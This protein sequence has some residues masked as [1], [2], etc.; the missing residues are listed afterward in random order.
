MRAGVKTNPTALAEEFLEDKHEA[1]SLLQAQVYGMHVWAQTRQAGQQLTLEQMMMDE[2]DLVTAESVGLCSPGQALIR[3]FFLAVHEARAPY[4]LSWRQQNVP[5][6]VGS[7][8]ATFKRGKALDML[9]IRQTVFSND[10]LAPA[11]S[12]WVNSASMD[13]AA[14][15]AAC[16]DYQ[17]VLSVTKMLPLK[18]L[19]LDCPSRDA[20]GAGRRFPRLVAGTTAREYHVDAAKASLVTTLANA[21][22]VISRFREAK[23]VGF[24][25]EWKPPGKV[26]TVQLSDGGEEAALFHL[27]SL[28]SVPPSLVELIKSKRLCGVKVNDDLKK[29]SADYPE[30]GLKHHL[31]DDSSIIPTANIV[32][33]SSL[34]VDVLRCAPRSCASL[35][36]LFELCHPDLELNKEICGAVWKVDWE[37]WPLEQPQLQYALNDAGASALCGL[38][39]LHPPRSAPVA[40]PP[41]PPQPAPS[42]PPVPDANHVDAGANLFNSLPTDVRANLVGGEGSGSTANAPVRTE[43]EEDDE[44]DEAHGARAAVTGDETPIDYGTM[45]TVLEAAR[46]VIDHWRESSETEPLKLPAFLTDEDRGALHPYCEGLGL[47]HETIVGTGGGEDERRLRVS[48]CTRAGMEVGGSSSD[49]VFG[50]DIMA[51]LR[52]RDDAWKLL[53]IKYDARHFMGN[54]FLMAQSKS[55]SLFKY[56]CVATSD[57][58][59]RVREGQRERVKAHLRKLFKQGEGVDMTNGSAAAAEIARVDAL[60]L[61]VKRK[62]WRSHCEYTIPEPKEVVRSLLSVYLFFKDLDDPETGRPF[63]SA[64]HEKRCVLELQYVA[65]GWLSDHPTIPLYR[66]GRV[67]KTGF[68][69][70]RCLRSSSALEGYH[71]PF[72]DAM[73]AAGH[74][75]GI[76]WMEASSNEFDWRWTVRALRTAG[77]IPQTVRHFNLAL[78]DETFDLAEQL[79]EGGGKLALPGWRR[80]KLMKAPLLCQGFHYGLEALKLPDAAVTSSSAHASEARWLADRL[81]ASEPIHTRRTA[82][83]VD[84]LMGEGADASAESLTQVALNRGLYLSPADATAFTDEV[85]ADERAR[86]LLA[87]RGY[88]ELQQA[89]RQRAP[90]RPAAPQL[91]LGATAG[92]NELPGPIGAMP[93]AARDPEQLSERDSSP[94]PDT[95]SDEEAAQPEEEATCP[96]CG[97]KGFGNAG[98]LATHVGKCSGVTQKEKRAAKKRAKR[99]DAKR[100]RGADALAGM[101]RGEV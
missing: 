52:F 25:C 3:H 62:Y 75:A 98:A 88:K 64:G 1:L 2:A 41:P 40:A 83:D 17:K 34:A 6:T 96:K 77:L 50:G 49:R 79:F 22:R 63:F 39:L 36:A 28:G 30:A 44:D 71:A 58:I 19:Y 35:K 61:R 32:E 55:S 9:K 12:V 56:F 48:R 87:E 51:R 46:D 21:Q 42:P 84:A 14:F 7:V 101:A 47:A 8:D 16:T 11:I 89:L 78:I 97:T 33:L 10:V 53:L 31:D 86:A 91:V 23:L 66:P 85:V 67:L 95:S 60:I 45:K 54:F 15:S 26:A 4:Q 93:I 13:D 90:P 24:D 20:G 43:E 29:L 80:T 99:A 74:R 94:P 92:T 69:L 73:A 72:N 65:Y 70:S 5:M 18:L 100:A 27:P 38:R 59:F 37:R 68:I 82:E 81:G 57:A 76:K